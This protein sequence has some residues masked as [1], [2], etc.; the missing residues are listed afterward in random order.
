MEVAPVS[1]LRK[2]LHYDSVLELDSQRRV[3]VGWR[4]VPRCPGEMTEGAGLTS[5]PPDSQAGPSSLASLLRC[6]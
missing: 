5:R 6:R 4:L 3:G 1:H 2:T